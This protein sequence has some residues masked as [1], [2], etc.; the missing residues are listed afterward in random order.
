MVVDGARVLNPGG[1][2][3]ADE[4][5]RHKALDAV[6]DLA[7]AGAPI[8]GA[9]AA[10]RG[11]HEL[12]RRLLEALFADRTAYRWVEADTHPAARRDVETTQTMRLAAE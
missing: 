11:G 8:R 7:L 4:F 3:R 9:Y 5:V 10:S 12:T 1:L 6:G 2:R